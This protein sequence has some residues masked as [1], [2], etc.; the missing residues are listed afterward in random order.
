MYSPRIVAR[1]PLK[2]RE[3]IEIFK[4]GVFVFGRE[5]FF[6]RRGADKPHDVRAGERRMISSALSPVAGEQLFHRKQ[7]IRITHRQIFFRPSGRDESG[8]VECAQ[9]GVDKPGRAP[10]PQLFGK[11]YGVIVTM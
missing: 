8:R 9:K 1:I 10:F 3:G 11:R 5:V 4:G 6:R 2:P 7:R